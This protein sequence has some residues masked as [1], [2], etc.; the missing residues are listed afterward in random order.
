MVVGVDASRLL[1]QFLGGGRGAQS[2]GAGGGLADLGRA[3]ASKAGG[4]GGGMAAGGLLGLLLGNKKARKLAGGVAGYGA[5]AALGALAFKAYQNWQS[6]AD[7]R[8]APVAS[9]AEMTVAP[10]P[11]FQPETSLDA[12]GAPFQLALVR[13]MIAVAKADGHVDAEEQKLLFE[14]VELMGLDAEG[15]AFVFDALGQDVSIDDVAKA[16]ATQEQAT[17]LYLASRLAIDPDHPAE[18]AYLDALGHRL[19]LPGDLIGHLN[20]Q[21]EQRINDVTA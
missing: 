16:A 5:A 9:D 17:E 11:A 14:Q 3:A 15:K 4:F 6:G 1:D 13:A 7:A 21:V 19:N 20:Q 18:R 2:G 10:P 12:D 8:T